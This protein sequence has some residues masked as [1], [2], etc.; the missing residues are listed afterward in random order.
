MK[1]PI[2]WVEIPVSDLERAIE[3]YNNAFQWSLKSFSAGPLSMAVL[4]NNGGA[5]A[6][7]GALVCQEEAYRTSSSDSGPL[8]YLHSDNID[9]QL[10]RIESA[11]GFTILP[12]KLINKDYGSMALF[13]DTEG[14]R[15]A[16][17]SRET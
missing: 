11:G 8:V 9:Q 3:F 17:F 7:S 1:N 10:D 12:R 14:N 4:P 5:E 13:R 6:C 2:V 15:M 16:L